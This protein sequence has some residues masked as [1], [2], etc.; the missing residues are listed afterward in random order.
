[1]GCRRARASTD[2][3]PA[4]QVPRSS[5]KKKNSSPLSPPETGGTGREKQ[6]WTRSMNDLF[7][8][9]STLG[10]ARWEQQSRFSSAELDCDFHPL[11][12]FPDRQFHGGSSGSYI[13]SK[14]PLAQCATQQVCGLVLLGGSNSSRG[15]ARQVRFAPGGKL[16]EKVTA[17]S[18]SLMSSWMPPSFLLSAS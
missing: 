16:V 10:G 18:A 8:L 11:V 15:S 1:M 9:S 12:K 7:S 17:P 14:S 5:S 13:R 3:P 4:R 6:D 2:P